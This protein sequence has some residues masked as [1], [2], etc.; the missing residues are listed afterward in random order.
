MN[1]YYVSVGLAVLGITGWYFYWQS[2]SRR[3]IESGYVPPAS[4]IAGQIGFAAFAYLLTFLTV[5]KVKVIR[6]ADRPPVGR[7]VFAANHQLPCDFAMV[8]RGSGRHFRMLTASEQLGGF[9]GL[10][11]A[12]GGVISVA[13]KQKSDGPA[14]E[15]GCVRAVASKHV[16]ISSKL[17]AAVFLGLTGAFIAATIHGAP[18]VAALAVLAALVVAALPGDPP[19][20]GIFPE[21]SLL[22]DNPN[23]TEKF[24]P[25]AVRIA[26][27]AAEACGEPVYIVPMAIHYRR[28]A[29][30]AD[31]TH[32]FLAGMRS[33]FL[34]IRNPKVWNPIFKVKL[35][36]LPEAEREELKRR[37]KEILRE[38]ARAK[39]TNYGGV[40]V[41]GEA[42]DPSTLPADPIEAITQVHAAVA[43]LY[44]EAKRH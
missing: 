23:L 3:F 11:A 9:F 44:E 42:I 38:Y 36:E 24:R 22:P 39:V 15:Q 40:V 12:A 6:R 31:W 2:H 43:A 33:M 21:G 1:I 28:D 37:Q 34:G 4:S 30:K 16:R 13:F 20:L 35:D 32:R 7:V 29:A 10:L 8:R 17:A 27:A 26:R 18:T 5:G 41:V 19:S 14:A 25:G